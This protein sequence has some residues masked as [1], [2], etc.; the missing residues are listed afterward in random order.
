MQVSPVDVGHSVQEL[1]GTRMLEPDIEAAISQRWK[2]ALSERATL[3]DGQIF[4]V[5]RLTASR[6]EGRFVPYRWLVAQLADPA[7]YPM[8]RVAPLAVMGRTRTSDGLIVFGLRSNETMQDPALWELA[9]AGG[10]DEGARRAFGRVDL[11]ASLVTELEEELAIFAG[12][13]ERMHPVGVVV[14]PDTHVHDVVIDVDVSLSADALMTRASAAATDEYDAFACL[15]PGADL[16]VA[17]GGDASAASR[18][19]FA[20]SFARMEP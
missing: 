5:E 3:V 18:A 16:D 6:I 15:P 13:I 4:S 7:L 20:L 11:V 19:A 2:D 1:A 10:V 9:P 14:D 17:L 8:I 12:D